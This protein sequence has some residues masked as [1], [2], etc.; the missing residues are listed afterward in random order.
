MAIM[1]VG[2]A[3]YASDSSS[4]GGVAPWLPCLY[5]GA[6]A[7]ASGLWSVVARDGRHVT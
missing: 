3:R 6:G 1:A 4:L 7:V 5:F 2:A